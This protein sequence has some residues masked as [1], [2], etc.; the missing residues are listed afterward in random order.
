MEQGNTKYADQLAF[1]SWLMGEE[2]GDE[3]VVT[4]IDEIVAKPG[5][6]ERPLLRVAQHRSRVSSAYQ[7]QLFAR[8]LRCWQVVEAGHI[9]VDRTREESDALCERLDRQAVG[10]MYS[11]D[12]DDAWFAQKVRKQVRY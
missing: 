12:E 7:E 10:L 3:S 5:P 9:F 4:C 1:Y 8:A 6:T 11:D 2:V